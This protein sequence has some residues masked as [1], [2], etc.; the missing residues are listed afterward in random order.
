MCVRA[1]GHQDSHVAEANLKLTLDP[2]AL[3]AR[4]LNDRCALPEPTLRNIQKRMTLRL[5]HF[6]FFVVVKVKWGE[7]VF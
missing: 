5:F 3:A 1:R 7:R 6:F 4:V 2:P